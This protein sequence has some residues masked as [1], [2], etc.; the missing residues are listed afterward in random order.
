M[1][2]QAKLRRRALLRGGLGLGVAALGLDA[3]AACAP[4]GAS[5]PAAAALPSPETKNLRI[6][7]A[8]CDAPYWM[9]GDFLREEGF[10]VDT[11]G[12]HLITDLGVQPLIQGDVNISIQ[13]ANAFVGHV[14][15]GQPLVALGGLHPG[16]AQVWARPGI[17]SISDLRGKTV[18]VQTK[19]FSY[20][21][22]T[23]PNAIFGFLSTLL[24]HVGIAPGA[25]NFVEIGPDLSPL[26]A[27]LAGKSDAYLAQAEQATLLQ[28]NPKNPGKLILDT[29][30][31]KP[32]SQVYCCLVTA[33][34]D[35]AKA[36]PVAAKR[37]T[38][39]ILRS[40]DALTKDRHAA[41]SA[42]IATGA[43]KASPE[44][45]EQVVSDT[46]KDMSYEWR[47]YDPED[48]VRFYALQMSDAKLITKTPQEIIA[49]GTD[50]AYFRQLRT[51]LKA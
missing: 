10:I 38:R 21:N 22:K 4:K 24:A 40:A 45:T 1:E 33:N 36:N 41:A 3:I 15:A 51:E 8:L 17:S 46:I 5:A 14:D 31:D 34:R 43:F 9:A 48:T 25:V 6:S 26:D 37:A 42:A 44:I 11:F 29:T 30:M 28:A 13:L 47:A 23:S 7:W 20:N 49:A 27:F 16:C 50:F 39:A 2:G 32:W 18:A 12:K 19:T 35:W